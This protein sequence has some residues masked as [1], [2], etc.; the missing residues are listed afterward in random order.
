[1]HQYSQKYFLL[2]RLMHTIIVGIDSVY[3]AEHRKAI[4]VVLVKHRTTP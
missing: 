2:L 3:T 1:V 4:F